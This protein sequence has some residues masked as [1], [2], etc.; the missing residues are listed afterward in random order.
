LCSL[1]PRHVSA[2]KF[3]PQGVTCSFWSYSSLFCVSG[4]WGYC[5]LGV[6]MCCEMRSWIPKHVGDVMSTINFLQHTWALVGFFHQPILLMVFIRNRKLIIILILRECIID[7]VEINQI[8]SLNYT[9]IYFSFTM[10]PTCFGK[11]V[12]S[13]GSDY[14]PFWATSAWIW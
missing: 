10:A 8:N 3:H 11:T 12:P 4:G 13:S 5:S 2:S 7:H 9:L 14:V 6:A 1:H